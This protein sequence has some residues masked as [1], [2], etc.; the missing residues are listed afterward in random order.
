MANA[1]DWS[2]RLKEIFG[3]P[4]ET[5]VT[6]EIFL[7]CVHPDDRERVNAAVMAALAGAEDGEYQSEYRI[8]RRTD[9]A[10]RWVTARGQAFFDAQSTPVRFIGTF[11]DGH[12]GPSGSATQSIQRLNAELERRVAERTDELAMT[13]RALKRAEIDELRKPDRD[14]PA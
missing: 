14:G 6:H 10:M 2:P 13:N 12:H 9:G 11:I 1:G 4:L 3:L 7:E 5:E 8:H